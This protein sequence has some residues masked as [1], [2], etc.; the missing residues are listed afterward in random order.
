MSFLGPPGVGP[1]AADGDA[2]TLA[3]VEDLGGDVRLD[4]T[5]QDDAARGNRPVEGGLLWREDPCHSCHRPFEPEPPL[6]VYV[7][8][9]HDSTGRLVHQRYVRGREKEGG[10]R[11]RLP[12]D[13]IFVNLRDGRVTPQGLL[14]FGRPELYDRHMRTDEMLMSLA[15]LRANKK[16]VPAIWNR[17]PANISKGVGKEKKAKEKPAQHEARPGERGPPP[18]P[19][20]PPGCRLIAFV[21]PPAISVV[22]TSYN[23]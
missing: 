3:D 21:S 4:F 1:A 17:K 13:T 7:A 12:G 15:D 10:G 14:C 6:E 5:P 16:T 11:K 19:F 2:G 8:I 9:G 22:M 23:G 18:P 20:L